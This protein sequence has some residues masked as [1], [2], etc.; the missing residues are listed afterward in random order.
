MEIPIASAWRCVTPE[1]AKG[2][3]PAKTLYGWQNPSHVSW[4][5][6]L[7]FLH[8][9]LNNAQTQH[10]N[11]IKFHIWLDKNNIL[12]R[13]DPDATSDSSF[14]H[15]PRKT[16]FFNTLSRGF[17]T[18]S[19]IYVI[20]PY[21]LLILILIIEKVLF[22]AFLPKQQVWRYFDSPIHLLI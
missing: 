12:N 11:K 16:T 4:H 3:A 18:F 8:G 19:I 17:P 21:T 22:S 7:Y 6:N 20:A 10:T 5:K 1:G 13:R 9:K 14:P 2:P 15:N